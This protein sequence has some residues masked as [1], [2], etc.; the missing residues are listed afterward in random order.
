MYQCSLCSK[1]F[2]NSSNLS[3]HVRSHGESHGRHAC[4]KGRAARPGGHHPL[5]GH[6]E[7]QSG[8]SLVVP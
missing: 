2:Q 6:P 7:K 5:H 3:R 8:S 1:I 4:S